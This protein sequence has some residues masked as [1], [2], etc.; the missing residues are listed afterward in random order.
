MRLRD[1]V[2]PVIFGVWVYCGGSR[3]LA[4][5]EEQKAK[6]I[7][8]GHGFQWSILCAMKALLLVSCLCCLLVLCQC[9]YADNYY[10]SADQL[11]NY[12]RLAVRLSDNPESPSPQAVQDVKDAS[13]CIG[14][15][16]GALDTFELLHETT[17]LCVP[18]E[19]KSVQAVRVFVKYADAHPEQLHLAGPTVLWEA[20]HEAFPCA[21]SK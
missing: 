13:L 1:A 17:K 4:T 9:A 16:T 11:A 18:M 12:C 20:M 14:Y 3:E 5:V 6:V 10:R 8:G 7:H 19:V 2:L 15:V 21:V